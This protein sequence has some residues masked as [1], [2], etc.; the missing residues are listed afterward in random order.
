[1]LKK[2]KL[3]AEDWVANHRKNRRLKAEEGRKLIMCKKCFTFFYNNK[4]H[5]EKPDYLERN[6]DD[7]VLV[8]FTECHACMEQDLASYEAGSDFA[9]Q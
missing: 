9:L 8:S 7:E 3:S 2:L 4:W 1:M 6:S 5:F